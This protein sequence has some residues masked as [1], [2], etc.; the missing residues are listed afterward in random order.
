M[1]NFID[2]SGKAR[3]AKEGDYQFAKYNRKV[4]HH[5]S[6]PWMATIALAS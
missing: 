3:P 4:D 1:K 5:Q 6:I 2:A